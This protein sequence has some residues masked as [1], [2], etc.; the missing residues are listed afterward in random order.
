MLVFAVEF[1]IGQQ[2]AFVT[3]DRRSSIFNTRM[4]IPV[5]AALGACRALD[6]SFSF[7]KGHHLHRAMNL[8]CVSNHS[9]QYSNWGWSY[10][11]IVGDP[12]TVK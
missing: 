1:D 11:D 3:G 4:I 5:I 6:R 9:T 12:P 7:R 8:F 10:V 2:A